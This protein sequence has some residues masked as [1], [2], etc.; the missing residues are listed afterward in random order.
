MRLPFKVAD[1]DGLPETVGNKVC[2]GPLTLAALDTGG[3]VL[4]WANPETVSIIITRLVI[5]IT[6]KS[7]AASTIDAGT[8]ASSA[9]TS[10]DNLIDGQDS[11]TA[12]AVFDN[13]E[14]PGSNGKPKQKLAVGKWVTISKAS[15]ACAG[16]VGKAYIEYIKCAA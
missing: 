9:T 3:G 5:D 7:T 16:L 4:S 2:T 15:G 12:A 14:N 11:G 6:T 8:T 1:I 13:Y 10:S